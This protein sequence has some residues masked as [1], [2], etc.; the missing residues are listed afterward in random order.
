MK[1]G[2]LSRKELLHT[3]ELR[4][5]KFHAP[6]DKLIEFQSILMFLEHLVKGKVRLINYSKLRFVINNEY[7]D[8]DG[9]Q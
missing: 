4:H 5:T 6:I 1:S 9:F 7:K 8:I 3:K 2:K